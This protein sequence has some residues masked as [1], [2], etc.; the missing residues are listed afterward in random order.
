MALD[1]KTGTLKWHFQFTP[2]DVWDYDAQETPALVDT[3]WLGQARKLLVQANRNGFFYVL[4][5]TNGRFLY[6]L[7]MV[8][9]INWTFGLDS[10]TGRPRINPAK[11]PRAGG[12][13]PMRTPAMSPPKTLSSQW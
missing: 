9:G 6:A 2:H 1:A 11:V 12:P 10:V 5:R 7:P 8:D 3:V 13:A 4:D